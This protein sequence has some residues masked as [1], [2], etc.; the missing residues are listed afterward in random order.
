MKGSIRV[1]MIGLLSIS[2]MLSCEK[3]DDSLNNQAKQEP[4]D[5]GTHTLETYSEINETEYLIV[6]ESGLGNGHSVWFQ[7]NILDEIGEL[8]DVL[9]YD[10][11]GYENSEVGPG[12]RSIERLSFE[13]ESVINQYING[14]K[15]ILVGHSLGGLVIRDYTIKNPNKVASILFIDPSHE[16]YNNPGQDGEDFLYDLMVELHGVNHGASMEM[17][18]L[19]EDIEYIS[20]R[21][22][23]PNIPI[24]VLTS[25]KEDQ[26]N[27]E[28]DQINSATRQD[29]FNA[30]E[31]LGEGITDFR[32][33]STDL[34][35]HY[36]M[37]EQPNLVIDELKLLLNK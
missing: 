32:H 23:L 30:H 15:V 5:L 36:I 24:T 27:L 21:P 3:E 34:A 33:L 13:L 4:I 8:S 22:N 7:N 28:A 20:T 14:R 6:F 16:S 31:E 26:S 19:I 17:R 11:A 35:G 29:W 1:L 10:R 25:M 37:L 12:P 2:V 9:L 18:Q